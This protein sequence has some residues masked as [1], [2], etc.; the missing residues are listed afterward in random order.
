MPFLR[1]AL[2]ASDCIGRIPARPFIR[3][4]LMS[5]SEPHNRGVPVGA[6]PAARVLIVSENARILLLLAAD[7]DGHRWWLAPGGGL[8]PGETFEVAARR[9]AAEET[10]AA[11]EIGPWVWTRRH[12]YD[13]YGRP[14]D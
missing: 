3:R 1:V 11:V 14:H 13:W 9:E 12:K 5:H 4:G 6:R 2:T 8:D 7:K 10:G